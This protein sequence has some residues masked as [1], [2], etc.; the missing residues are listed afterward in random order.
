MHQ[1]ITGSTGVQTRLSP[2]QAAHKEQAERHEKP[3]SILFMSK[4]VTA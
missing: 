1:Q 2:C 3:K 4:Q